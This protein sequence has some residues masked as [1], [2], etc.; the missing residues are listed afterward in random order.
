MDTLRGL[1]A[2][3]LYVTVNQNQKIFWKMFLGVKTRP[4]RKADYFPAN[5]KPIV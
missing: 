2:G 3:F 5:Y 4:A 1:S